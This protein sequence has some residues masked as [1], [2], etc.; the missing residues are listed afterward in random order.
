MAIIPSGHG[1]LPNPQA[2][3]DANGAIPPAQYSA[4]PPN[5]NFPQNGDGRFW[6]S[7][8]AFAPNPAA[9]L[10]TFIG[11][12]L[13]VSGTVAIQ[14]SLTQKANDGSSV[15]VSYSTDGVTFT[16]TTISPQLQYGSIQN[17]QI[18]VPLVANA[19]LQIKVQATG[20]VSSST[21][22]LN[23]LALAISRNFNEGISWDG[24]TGDSTSAQDP[25]NYNCSR[26]DFTGFPSATLAQLRQRLLIRAGFAAQ[27]ASPPPAIA[28]FMNDHLLGSQNYLYRKYTALHTRRFFRWKLN[29]GQRFYS[30]KDNDEDVLGKFQLDPLK[31][32]EWVGIQDS[33]NV[34]YPMIEGIPP[35]LYTM[36]SKPW[37]PAR[38]DIRQAIEVYPAPDQT[39]YMWVR[40]NF[41]LLSFVNDSDTTTIDSELVFLH[42]LANVKAHYGHPDAS[43][44]EAQANSYRGELV[45]GSHKTAHYIPGVIAVPPAVR[46]TLIQF[47]PQGS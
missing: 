7:V 8:N 24:L 35:Q 44:I 46:P 32:I 9:G 47:N 19:G 40:A 16:N 31:T 33:R 34:W 12:P 45:A 43:N 20:G 21:A 11:D 18:V 37:R 42:A 28:A 22:T 10:I 5:T 29:P 25:I 2:W 6:Y 14:W 15:V 38:Y 27:A 26:L 36:V 17:G 39:Y 23:Q 13:Y 3:Q 30:L 41:G 4:V 1:D